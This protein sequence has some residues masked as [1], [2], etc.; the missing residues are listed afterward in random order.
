MCWKTAVKNMI[1]GQRGSTMSTIKKTS[2]KEKTKKRD[3]SI[4]PWF[5]AALAILLAFFIILG[6]GIVNNAKFRN[7]KD[8]L[9]AD[10]NYVING[11]SFELVMSGKIT[12][13]GSS[14]PD[15]ILYA[16]SEAG[17]GKPFKG[18]TLRTDAVPGSINDMSIT[19][20]NGNILYIIETDIYADREVLPGILVS[21]IS[22]GKVYS[23][24]T[25]Q[26]Q[27]SKIKSCIH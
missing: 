16:L 21:Y 14:T 22:N 9:Q 26:L 15:A 6:V 19:F 5:A 2:N 10:V 17:P 18:G 1:S 23:Y 7:F 8:S 20:G 4:L 12:E 13:A 27:F 3:R 25:P 11:G 24:D